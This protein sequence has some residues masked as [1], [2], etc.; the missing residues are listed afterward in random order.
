MSPKELCYTL[1]RLY[2]NNE[3]TGS[4]S[5]NRSSAVLVESFSLMM[6]TTPRAWTF[7]LYELM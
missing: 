1:F 3:C 2:T 5:P 6:G 7:G 4:L